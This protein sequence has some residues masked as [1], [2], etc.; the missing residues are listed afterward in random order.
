M[1]NVVERTMLVP[2]IHLLTIE[3]PQVAAK[4]EPGHFVIVKVDEYAERIPLTVADWD[5]KQGTVSCVFMQVG[6]STRKMSAL[7]VGDS[8]STFVGPLGKVI[9]IDHYGTV[10]CVGGCYGI[11]SIYPVAKALKEKGNRV[12]TFIEARS[13]FLLYWQDK[14]REVSDELI[15]STN[16]RSLGSKGHNSDRLKDMLKSGESIDHV[17]A[18]GCT[19]MLYMVSEATRPF[20]VKTIVSLNPVMVDGTGMCGACRVEV[21][22]AT[23]FAC[24][25]GPDFD[26][27]LVDWNLLM[28][29]RKAYVSQETLSEEI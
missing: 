2:N 18:M 5:E 17:V 20:E 24:V 25:D 1:N 16:D 12:L 19:Y 8:V 6:T 14:L 13:S 27:H 28:A 22:G 21:G 23:K 9:D 3:S 11:G 7:N 4:I 29:R 10:A 15:I 26:G